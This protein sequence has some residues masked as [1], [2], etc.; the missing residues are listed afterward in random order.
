[1][2]VSCASNAL[3]ALAITRPR[4]SAV[5]VDTRVI[6]RRTASCVSLV[7]SDAGSV[8]RK[9]FASNAPPNVQVS[10]I[11]VMM[12]GLIL[13]PVA[14]QVSSEGLLTTPGGIR[15]EES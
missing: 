11:N 7:A 15:H 1:M 6:A 9:L 12:M 8:L 2:A 4:M 10:V 3:L 5:I 13:A 14:A